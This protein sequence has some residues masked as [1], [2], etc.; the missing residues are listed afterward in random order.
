MQPMDKEM[1]RTMFGE[2]AV[3]IA[4]LLK[5]QNYAAFH[6]LTK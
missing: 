5:A 3:K 2:D 6:Q 1:T 4:I